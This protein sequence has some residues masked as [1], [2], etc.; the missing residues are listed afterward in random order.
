MTKEELEKE[1]EDNKPPYAICALDTNCELWKDGYKKGAEPREKR[2]AE[3]E[4]QIE[5]MRCCENCRNYNNF[6]RHCEFDAT[7]SVECH[8]N[9]YKLW[10]IKEK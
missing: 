6:H 2:I 3:L 1:A 7:H 9:N 5:K 10:E 4:A 8:C